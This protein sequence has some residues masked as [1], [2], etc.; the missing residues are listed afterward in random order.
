MTCEEARHLT[1]RQVA[2]ESIGS[3]QAECVRRHLETCEPCR[4]HLEELLAARVLQEAESPQPPHDLADS[5]SRAARTYMRYQRR[6]MHQ[7]AL[8]SPAFF[9]TCASLLCGAIICLLASLRV[10]AVP[11]ANTGVVPTTVV[12][13]DSS[14][15]SGATA[16][17]AQTTTALL[18]YRRA[19]GYLT[20]F[21]MCLP[22]GE[23]PASLVAFYPRRPVLVNLRSRGPARLQPT[24]IRRARGDDMQ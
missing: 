14:G 7:K 1:A 16:S 23:R 22:G 21:L 8:G 4:L 2:G 3:C 20:E 11:E 19:T 10:A 5:I 6:P 12:S 17:P 9:A 13:R 18:T 15:G 24:P